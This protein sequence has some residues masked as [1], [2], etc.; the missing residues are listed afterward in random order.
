MLD[1]YWHRQCQRKHLL[2]DVLM[3]T[4]PLPDY[5]SMP[6][7]MREY[8]GPSLGWTQSPMPTGGAGGGIVGPVPSVVGDFA[9]WANTTGTQL[10]DTTPAQATASLTIFSAT[11][12]GIVPLSGGG[13]SNFLRADGTWTAPPVGAGTP[14]GGSV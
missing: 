13:T 9:T 14:P 12:K 10:A 8:W 1:D 7:T 4:T 3:P 5:D 2:W 6:H 11:A